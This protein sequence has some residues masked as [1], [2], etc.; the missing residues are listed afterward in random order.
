MALDEYPQ[1]ITIETPD[2]Y[3]GV[4]PGNHWKTYIDTPNDFHAGRIMVIQKVEIWFGSNGANTVAIVKVN[5]RDDPTMDTSGK[6]QL[7]GE[8]PSII[9]VEEYQILAAPTGFRCLSEHDFSK[10]GGLLYP[11]KKIYLHIQN[12][13][14]STVNVGRVS[15][16]IWYKFT[17][18]SAEE[19]A[20][21][22]ASE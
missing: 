2:G 20:Q 11:Y 14:S 3:G 4:A 7:Y 9:V 1:F 18:V 5:G 12:Q 13:T 17:R 8:D 22:L 16:R 15:V 6:V 21:L 19:L 10:M